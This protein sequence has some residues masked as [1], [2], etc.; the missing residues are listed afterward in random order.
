M[1]KKNNK[2]TIILFIL[3]ILFILLIIFFIYNINKN[4]IEKFTT[5]ILGEN[6]LKT[7]FINLDEHI[8]R[9]NIN[10][11]KINNMIR[12]NAIHGKKLDKSNLIKNGILN[13]IN[14]LLPGQLG[15]ALSHISVMNLIKNQKEE[16]GLILE[17]DV[18]IPDNFELIFN[19]LIKNCPEKWD[20]IFLGG[21]NIYGK[22][23]NDNFI[24]P[25]DNN[26]SK[27]LCMHAVLLNKNNVDKIINVLQPLYRPIDS[28]LREYFNTLD[29]FYAFPNIINQNKNLISNR[30]VIDG[31]PQSIYWKEN[32][33]NIEIIE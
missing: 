29:V 27:N 4:K 9:W 20:I 33:L 13:N 26:G 2:I 5:N 15:C 14:E 1:K 28:Q 3:F 30:R 12:F 31:L 10:K 32:H 6:N 22:K 23:Y 11:N 18:I 21:C 19:N 7:Y 8:D 16:Y 24:I 17:D 25:L